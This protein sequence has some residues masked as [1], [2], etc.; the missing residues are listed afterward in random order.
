MEKYNVVH[1][2]AVLKP[3]QPEG[4][5]PINFIADFESGMFLNYFPQI[6]ILHWAVYKK[7]MLLIL[8]FWIFSYK[9]LNCESSKH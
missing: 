6:K 5:V 8:K 1:G 2:S 4:S 9:L 3:T 7:N